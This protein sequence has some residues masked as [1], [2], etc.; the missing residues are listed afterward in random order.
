MHT[1][2]Q[3]IGP[4]SLPFA[5]TGIRIGAARTQTTGHLDANITEVGLTRYATAPVPGT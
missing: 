4:S 2:I 5:G 3:E 1:V